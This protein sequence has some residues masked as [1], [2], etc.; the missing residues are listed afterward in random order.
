M[1]IV[2]RLR[3]YA[4]NNRLL[5]LIYLKRGLRKVSCTVRYTFKVEAHKLKRRSD[6]DQGPGPESL[7]VN[8]S[9]RKERKSK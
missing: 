5:Y 2:L 8:K 9:L 6:E 3:K 1:S 7:Q 4:Q